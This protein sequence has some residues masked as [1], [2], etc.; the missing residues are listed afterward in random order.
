MHCHVPEVVWASLSRRQHVAWWTGCWSPSPTL[1][2]ELA[3]AQAGAN[4]VQGRLVDA[5]AR[6][7]GAYYRFNETTLNTINA[8]LHECEFRGVS[9]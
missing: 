5:V 2:P 1:L 7:D 9:G 8:S 4:C 6:A 3:P